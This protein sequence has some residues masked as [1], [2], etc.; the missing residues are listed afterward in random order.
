MLALT[1]VATLLA[2]AAPTPVDAL[3]DATPLA[4]WRTI[5]GDNTSFAQPGFDDA[6]WTPTDVVGKLPTSVPGGV[7]WWRTSVQFGARALDD[8]AHGLT[9]SM[10]LPRMVGP[11]TVYVD[12]VVVADVGGA[13][14]DT[15]FT[16][17]SA[18]ALPV[19]SAAVTIA[20]RS[21]TPP[22][23][24][25]FPDVDRPV[26]PVLGS[27]AVTAGIAAAA[28][29]ALHE[30]V[31]RYSAA[32]VLFVLAALY[33]LL[34]WW[35]RRSLTGY[36]WYGLATLSVAMLPLGTALG[37][38]GH[39]NAPLFCALSMM[40]PSAFGSC[41]FIAFVRL[42]RPG[43]KTPWHVATLA[44]WSTAGSVL[45]V[46]L[47]W[48]HIGVHDVLPAMINLVLLP[49]IVVGFVLVGQV[50]VPP[51]WR[52]D[53]L[54]R[55]LFIG[56]IAG[57]GAAIVQNLGVQGVMT[58][59]H[60]LGMQ[61]LIVGFGSF[62]ICM[63]LA[64]NGSYAQTL[65]DLDRKNHELQ[66]INLSMSRFLPDAF[67]ALLSRGSIRDVV[68]GDNTELEITVLF[69]D[70]RG[71]TTISE[72]IGTRGVFELINRYLEYVEPT[73]HDNHGFISQY[74]GDGVMALFATNVD[75]A[76]RC[77][78]QMHRAVERF[79]EGRDEPLTIGVGLNTGTLMLGTIGG[80]NRLAC[81]VIGDPV[82]L[83]ARIEGMTK[84]YGARVLI[85]D[86]T[87]AKLTSSGPRVRRLDR[88]VAKGKTLPMTLFEVIDAD[89]PGLRDAKLA[90]REKFEHAL[91]DLAAARF[92]DA[93][94]AFSEI[95][96]LCPQDTAAA[97][98]ALRAQ[99]LATE[100]VPPGWDGAVRLV[101]K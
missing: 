85:S 2:T 16:L 25:F 59:V 46:G 40:G 63:A 73:I 36:L 74:Y 54:A 44:I 12:G 80:L 29:N 97:A 42:L 57:F 17:P 15:G 95:A 86:V 5:E 30:E 72:K 41:W 91:D 18:I 69:S 60:P 6:A 61:P 34:L 52:G 64:L 77:T 92:D 78:V 33:H 94:R 11:F 58:P 4:S 55:L 20:L 51:M 38:A 90:S 49:N 76:V 67:L 13:D 48:A 68:R 9:A 53:R 81:N 10:T 32:T 37:F 88:V 100:G 27:A 8:V 93:Q 1:V 96:Q 35:R 66:A 26:T 65:N 23:V 47:C 99:T 87:A 19:H 62:G 56:Y 39:A 79:N 83:A 21:T 45:T 50:V 31:L 84:M 3:G 89:P 82:N 75:D 101:D 71:F 22:M 7:T 14:I 28:R 70:I 98:L 24:M 43:Q